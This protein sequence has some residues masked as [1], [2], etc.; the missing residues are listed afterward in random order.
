[1][2]HPRNKPP[3]LQRV[4]RAPMPPDWEQNTDVGTEYDLDDAYRGV[5]E[6]SDREPSRRS[7]E[8]PREYS[9]SGNEQGRSGKTTT[10]KKEHKG[11]VPDAL[12]TE[13]RK[14]KQA[15]VADEGE[16]EE[17]P[18]R[19]SSESVRKPFKEPPS[20]SQSIWDEN[21]ETWY[22]MPDGL[23]YDPKRHDIYDRESEP[24]E[25]ETKPLRRG[26][27]PYV[28]SPAK[29]SAQSAHEK[30]SSSSG[31]SRRRGDGEP[32]RTK[33]ERR[34]STTTREYRRSEETSIPF[35]SVPS[36]SYYDP[37]A[38]P[39]SSRRPVPTAFVPQTPTYKFDDTN[40]PSTRPS[41]W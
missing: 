39:V 9:S 8:R 24:A 5:G 20:G 12:R 1:M 27:Q 41:N 14:G 37:R 28:S 2:A 16:Q 13:R 15:T 10:R 38:V 19:R 26:S 31:S 4:P 40:G 18:R 25:F 32:K 7:G 36:R 35:R 23:Y 33:G 29:S 6:G 17:E 34:A 3:P 22:P 21:T 30:S 11:R